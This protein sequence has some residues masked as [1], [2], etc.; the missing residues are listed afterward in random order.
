MGDKFRL[1][2]RKSKKHKTKTE[3]HTEQVLAPQLQITKKVKYYKRNK[4]EMKQVRQQ[5]W[6]NKH[7]KQHSYVS[8]RKPGA[9]GKKC[10]NEL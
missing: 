2:K 8:V 1:S 10:S 7:N 4:Q 5:R 6:W 9:Q 3:K